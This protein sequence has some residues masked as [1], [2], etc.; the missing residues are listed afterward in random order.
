MDKYERLVGH[1]RLPLQKHYCC[2]EFCGENPIP[3]PSMEDAIAF[4]GE[5]PKLEDLPEWLI[6]EQEIEKKEETL[7]GFYSQV[8][9]ELICD[10][11]IPH[12]A[13]R[14]YAV[15]HKF[16]KVKD[17]S[18]RPKTFVS[19]KKIGKLMGGS[20]VYVWMN[21]KLLEQRGWLEV[22]SRKGT[23]NIITLYDTPYNK[24]SE[25]TH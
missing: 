11:T 8:P 16:C 13:V 20:E 14:L 4:L 15:Y 19:K 22:K 17:L 3:V 18:K 7:E 2:N 9:H 24:N 5:P 21:T 25:M 12:A 1:R 23:T 6:G 10:P